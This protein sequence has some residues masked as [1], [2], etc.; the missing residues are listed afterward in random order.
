MVTYKVNVLNA[1]E[2]LKMIKKVNF[3]MYSLP[4]FKR[5]K[6][7]KKKKTG[8]HSETMEKKMEP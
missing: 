8:S 2:N 7:L 3:V 5:K 6:Q 1:T 4:K